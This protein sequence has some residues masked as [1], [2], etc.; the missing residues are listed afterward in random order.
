MEKLETARR[1]LKLCLLS[2][3]FIY[4]T[5]DAATL[6]LAQQCG[7]LLTSQRC[8]FE[9]HEQDESTQNGDPDLSKGLFFLL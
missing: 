8:L 7:H 5:T 2:V 6:N 1:F 3:S 9:Q 4:S